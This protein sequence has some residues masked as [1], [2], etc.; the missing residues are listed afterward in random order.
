MDIGAHGHLGQ[1]AYLFVEVVQGREHVNAMNR[2][3]SM[4]E[5]NVQGKDSRTLNAGVDT[6]M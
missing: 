6:A 3:Q 2:N 5:N 1:T 4:V